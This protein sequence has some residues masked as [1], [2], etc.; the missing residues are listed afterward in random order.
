MAFLPVFCRSDSF[1]KLLCMPLHPASS[2]KTAIAHQSR[3]FFLIASSV[4][5]GSSELTPVVSNM[6]GAVRHAAQKPKKA[7][8]TDAAWQGEQAFAIENST[9]Y[10]Q[11]DTAVQRQQREHHEEQQH[12]R[13]NHDALSNSRVSVV[14]A[15]AEQ[16]GPPSDKSPDVGLRGLAEQGKARSPWPL[17]LDSGTPDG[18]HPTRLMSPEEGR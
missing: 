17:G 4:V 1:T 6:H 13:H 5:D 16:G 3:P 10:I 7:R 18:V 15:R 12:D 9:M 14:A 2:L 8:E 11:Q